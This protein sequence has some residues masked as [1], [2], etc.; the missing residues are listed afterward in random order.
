MDV[1]SHELILNILSYLPYLDLKEF[2]MTSTTNKLY[3]ETHMDHILKMFHV[4]FPSIIMKRHEL[5]DRI[6]HLNSYKSRPDMIKYITITDDAWLK[7]Q[8]MISSHYDND[9][10]TDERWCIDGL[11]HRV[12]GPALLE[13]DD[14]IMTLERWY[15]NGKQHRDNGPATRAWVDGIMTLEGWYINGK[16]HRDNGH[17]IKAWDDGM[18]TKEEWY[19]DGLLHRSDGPAV[20][21]CE[22]RERM[23]HKWSIPP[24]W[25]PCSIN[26][27]YCRNEDSGRM[28]P[29]WKITRRCY[30]INK[31]KGK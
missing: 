31:D 25:C 30:A 3:V 24:C 17:A 11:L 22:N 28:V 26:M 18:L 19:I 16:K 2:A 15:I 27:G 1:L 9:D 7:N 8:D 12:C 23:V 20:L 4:K 14:M 6:F 10:L 13:W 5:I 29:K 21:K